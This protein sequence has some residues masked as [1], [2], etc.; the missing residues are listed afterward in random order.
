MERGVAMWNRE[1]SLIGWTITGPSGLYEFNGIEPGEYYM[2]LN[3]RI[4]PSLRI[5][6]D[7]TTIIDHASQPKFEL[8]KEVWGPARVRFAQSFIA[9]GTAVNGFSLWRTSGSGKFLVSLF[10]DSPAGKRVAGPFETEKDMVW[11]CGSSLPS[12]EFVTSPGKVY[13]LEIASAEGATWNHSMPRT[14][15]VYPNGIAYYDGVAHPESDLG[16]TIDQDLGGPT[17]IA[18][19]RDDLHF[20]PEG[21]GSGL[22]KV[23]G[24]SFIATAPNVVQAFANCGGWGAGAAEFIFSIHEDGPGGEQ[25]GPSCRVKMVC[26][27]GADALWFPDAVKLEPGRRYYLQYHRMDNEPFF[28]Y[29]SS[30]KYAEGRAFRDGEVLPEQFD[31][32]CYIVGEQEPDS[33]TYPYNVTV[34]EVTSTSALIRWRTG[35]KSNSLVDFGTDRYLR[36][37][38]SSESIRNTEH[39][40][41]L[42]DLEPG[43]VYLYRVSSDTHKKGSRRTYSRIESFLTEPAG[44]DLPRFDKPQNPVTTDAKADLPLIKNPGFEQG[45]E[46]WKRKTRKGRAKE[47]D[48]YVPDAKPFGA[49]TVGADGYEP[50]TGSRLYGW[51]FY[52]DQ[53]HT[54]T[55]G[56]ED[57][58]RE[59]IYQSIEVEQGKDYILTAWLLT[60]D[61][62]SG[63]GRD[64]RIRLTVDE[65]GVGL[66]E[67]FETTD[68]A[69][70]TQ[71]FATRHQMLRVSLRFRAKADHVTIGA[72]FL[73]WWALEANHLY[74]DDFSVRFADPRQ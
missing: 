13:A 52:A 5:E 27:W 54:W 1:G 3:G 6:D 73:Q 69:N 26:N 15:D 72:E 50:R 19:A 64:C 14:P 38:A 45:I 22:C 48:T 70:V 32:L 25:V 28:S 56:R 65:R 43:T 10:K 57:W 18:A 30:N 49:S 9:Q 60:G 21:P 33:I 74:I 11:I 24:Q 55:E 71:W 12:N 61:R 17:V 67:D 58:K 62:G 68:L 44:Q 40:V 66:L 46:G 47:P 16:I 42:K 41:R 31:Q 53:D 4:V 34:S 51:S 7:K 23:A 39:S 63:W 59:V 36:K 2:L 35:T 20:I 37:S 29:L 8:E